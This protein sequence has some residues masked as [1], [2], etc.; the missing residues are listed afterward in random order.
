MKSLLKLSSYQ[1][2]LPRTSRCASTLL[3]PLRIF[4][5]FTVLL[6]FAVTIYTI[7]MDPTPI[8][9]L[10]CILLIVL[11]GVYVF[12]L[13]VELIS[14]FAGGGVHI[15]PMCAFSLLGF[16]FFGSAA[17]L[18]ISNN[19]THL[20]VTLA[21][22][23]LCTLAALLF[24]IDITMIF[25]FWKRRCS[26]CKRCCINDTPEFLRKIEKLAPVHID[27]TMKYDVATSVSDIR[28]PDELK[29][30]VPADHSYRKVEY[31]PRRQY[32]DRPT[33]VPSVS[34]HDVAEIQTEANDMSVVE[35][36][37]PETVT[38]E[39]PM[40]TVS[41]CDF[42]HRIMEPFV[43]STIEDAVAARCFQQ[44]PFTYPAVVHFVR[45]G[46]GVPC[47]RGCK[48]FGKM[49]MQNQ[50]Q[51]SQQSSSKGA[52]VTLTSEATQQVANDNV[53]ANFT[54]TSFYVKPDK[55]IQTSSKTDLNTFK[56][57]VN[58]TKED[59]DCSEK[60]NLASTFPQDEELETELDETSI[61]TVTTKGR[62]NRR[63]SE[64][65]KRK[66]IDTIEHCDDV[67]RSRGGGEQEVN[68]YQQ[69]M[70]AI[71]QRSMISTAQSTRHTVATQ[72]STM[73]IAPQMTRTKTKTFLKSNRIDPVRDAH[74][75]NEAHIS[76][77][78]SFRTCIHK[79][80]QV[81]RFIF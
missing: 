51:S 14:H 13:A 43:L 3:K 6:I 66:S 22:I 30:I 48:C 80:V 81:L 40:Q 16:V 4:Q 57:T 62:T 46:V 44:A 5:F 72:M 65:K 26:I 52:N 10:A 20:A 67:E 31:P 11:S 24:L 55:N 50:Q 58:M 35:S 15:T 54:V 76:E 73:L 23:L 49:Q 75:N 42:C 28:V 8:S 7:V 71:E 29:S 25:V 17:I 9:A 77:E 38:I 27:E 47:C 60:A 19:Y 21:A 18:L 45:G 36:Q 69:F 41:K 12:V 32:V 34:Y 37:T 63:H 74:Q 59:A 56:Q 79:I 68:I 61:Q 78:T 70:H 2:K 39:R 53:A 64:K 1:Q 33:S